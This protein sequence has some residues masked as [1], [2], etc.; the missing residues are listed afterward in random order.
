[1]C[2]QQLIWCACGH[3]EILPIQKCMRAQLLGTCFVIIHGDHH[4]VLPNT[5]SYCKAGLQRTKPL[6]SARPRGSLVA[7]VEGASGREELGR[8]L[9]CPD[10][11]PQG[12][13]DEKVEEESAVK[14]EGKEEGNGVSDCGGGGMG[15]LEDVLKTEFQNGFNLDEE[16]GDLWRYCE[17]FEMEDV[18]AHAEGSGSEM[19]L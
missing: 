16:L 8:L 18:N 15:E 9:E 3:G 12:L 4:I 1:M 2:T 10:A 19:Q 5:C 7:K 14:T 17:G 6:G 13:G 11:W